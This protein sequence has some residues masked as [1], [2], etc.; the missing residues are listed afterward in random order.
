MVVTLQTGYPLD[1]GTYPLSPLTFQWIGAGCIIHPRHLNKS[2][3]KPI[4]HASCLKKNQ[5]PKELSSILGVW[6][7][8]ESKNHHPSQA[9][10]TNQNQRSTRS[11]YFK[12]L[13]EP[14]GLRKEL[15]RSPHPRG[16][17]GVWGG[18][19]GQLFEL[20]QKGWENEWSYN[21]RIGYLIFHS[22]GY[23]PSQLPWYPMVVWC[24]F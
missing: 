20:F 22:H 11:G 14:P 8:S 2:E 13:K 10:E 19:S 18:F 3:S 12:P 21:I 23:Q 15:A 6:N 24:S 17:A 16:G 4:I 5:N 7:K 9:F 1:T